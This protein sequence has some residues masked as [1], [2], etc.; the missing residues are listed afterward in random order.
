VPTETSV[1]YAIA[2]IASSRQAASAG[3][4]VAFV[5]SPQAQGSWRNTVSPNRELPSSGDVDCNGTSPLHQT[6]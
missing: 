2:P 1:L 5:Q 3:K 4:F 6:H